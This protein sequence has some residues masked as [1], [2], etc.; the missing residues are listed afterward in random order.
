M[1]GVPKFTQE[2]DVASACPPCILAKQNKASP[3][4][5]SIQTATKPH[6]GLSIDFSF[7]G[8]TSDNAADKR[9]YYEGFNGKTCWILV[10]DHFTGMK[11]GDTRTS[12]AS[13]IK[14][15]P[16]FLSQYSPGENC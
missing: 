10:T 7:S 14:W 16:Y 15:L 13:L 9:K 3:S 4:N 2:S 6:Q 8:Q 1:T 11:Y 12:K 5:H